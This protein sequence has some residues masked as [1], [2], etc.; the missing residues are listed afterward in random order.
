VWKARGDLDSAD[1]PGGG[2]RTHRDDHA[3]AEPAGRDRFETGPPHGHRKAFFEM[4]QGD[5]LVHQGLFE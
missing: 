1:R 5:A 2:E 3:A 4:A